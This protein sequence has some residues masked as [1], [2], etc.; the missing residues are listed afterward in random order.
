MTFSTFEPIEYQS[1][2]VAGMYYIVKYDI[3]NNN[4]MQAK[5]FEPLSGANKAPYVE[6]TIDAEGVK[7]NSS[8]LKY[9]LY[10]AV[11]AAT[12]LLA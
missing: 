1:Q 5:I 11:L 8:S 3:G 4:H 2:V 9:G 12:Y 6:W 7:N 10:S